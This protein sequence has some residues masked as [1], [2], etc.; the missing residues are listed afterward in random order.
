MPA[1]FPD[2]LAAQAAQSGWTAQAQRRGKSLPINAG[3]TTDKIPDSTVL[4]ALREIDPRLALEWRPMGRW[5]TTFGQKERP[6]GASYGAWRLT[7]K[8]KSG[9]RMGLKLCPPWWATSASQGE[10]AAYLSRHWLPRLKNIRDYYQ[11]TEG[12][13]DEL[14][15]KVRRDRRAAAIDRVDHGEIRHESRFAHAESTGAGFSGREFFSA[16]GSGPAKL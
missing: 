7:L 5:W 11:T 9:Q 1:I 14:D 13:S 2:P 15:D 6:P 16:G 12:F 8:G 4:R 10:L 3:A